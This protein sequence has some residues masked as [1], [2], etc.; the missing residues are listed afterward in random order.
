MVNAEL[1][2]ALRGLGS[3]ELLARNDRLRNA[4]RL[5]RERLSLPFAQQ[6]EHDPWDDGPSRPPSSLRCT[7]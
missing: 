3:K 1:E 6:H 5:H 2:A 4:A 7:R